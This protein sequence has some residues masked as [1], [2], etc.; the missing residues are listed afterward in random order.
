[1]AGNAPLSVAAAK[2]TIAESLKDPE[3]R[4]LDKIQELVDKC[5]ASEDYAEGTAAFMDKC[6]PRF[7]GR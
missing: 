7:K 4:N 3:K 2:L 6:K 5:Y 1:M